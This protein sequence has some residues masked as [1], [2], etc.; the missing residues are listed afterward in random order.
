MVYDNI[1]LLAMSGFFTFVGIG[2]LIMIVAITLRGTNSTKYRR[3]MSDL[4]IVGKIK[5]FAKEDNV[6][7]I[8]EMRDFAKY[9]KVKKIDEEALDKTIERELQEKVSKSTEEKLVK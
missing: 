7:L 9:L 1:G 5:Q 8:E 3:M 2:V 6:N 4:Y